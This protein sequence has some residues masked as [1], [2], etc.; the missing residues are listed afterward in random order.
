MATSGLLPTPQAR[1]WKGGTGK[2]RH[3]PSIVDALIFSRPPHP[4]RPLPKQAIDEARRMTA[5]SGRKLLPLYEQSSQHGASLRM[6]TASLLLSP[7]WYSRNCALNWKES[8]T[9]Y[10]RLLFRL[11]PSARHTGETAFGLLRTPLAHQPGI[12]VGQLMTKD[13][14]PYRL[15]QT[16]Y[17]RHTGRQARVGLTQQLGR[18][19]GEKLQLQPAFVSWMMG[20]PEGYCDFPTEPPSVKPDGARKRSKR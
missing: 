13:G 6:S 4:V 12:P 20:L 16:A 1:D 18:A 15:G 19:T 7:V 9:R 8:V 3:S 10:N 5:G 14:Q 17:D 11:L 2:N